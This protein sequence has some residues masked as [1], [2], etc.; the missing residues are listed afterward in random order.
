MNTSAGDT[1]SPEATM[2]RRNPRRAAISGWIGSALE[3]Y[4][5]ALYSTVAA[6]VFPG[7]FFPS[8]NPTVAIIA[9]LA[10]YA[11]GYVSRPLGAVVLGAYGD[12][13][14]RKKVLVFA[15]LLMGTA[16]FAVG[17]LPTYRQVGLLAPALLVAL[18]LIQGF[19][20]A[21]E[22]GGASA[23]IV[24]H[25]PDAKRGFFASFS[26]QGTQVGSILATAALLPLS[27]MLPADQFQSWGWRVPF[28]LSA[29]VILAGYLI[30]RRVQEP[31]AYVAQS[32][33]AAVKRRFPLLELLRS[34]PWVLVRC[35]L[36]TFTNVIGMATLVF[37]VSYATQKGYG[38]GF[39][40]G[41]FLWVT[42]VANIVAVILIPVFGALSDRI[43]RRAL[44]VVGGVGGGLLATAYLWAID[45]RSLV[46]VFVFVVIV[47][48]ALFQMWNATFATFF[49]EQFPLRIRVTGFAVAQNIGLMIAS[50]FPSIF[51][52]IAP[53]GTANVPLVI[54]GATFGICVVAGLAA[55]LSPDTKGK[56]LA[57][58]E[59]EKASLHPR[60]TSGV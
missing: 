29:F 59:D 16:T 41:E 18:R 38:I 32:A 2:G 13:H 42:L 47:Q 15:M 57:D 49:Q 56:S 24:E 30:R 53:P 17:L 44:M 8:G 4:D 11:V 33:Q 26:L 58:L 45:Q 27:A 6:L 9:S 7:I 25:S 5:F 10:T 12:R 52:A 39:S 43:G 1:I 20:V 21:G 3:Y 46:L 34:Y 60:S 22:L 54:G 23:M 28:L 35:I 31:P 40:A 55:L 48:G 14:G 51:T 37:G 36:M 50:F 19:A